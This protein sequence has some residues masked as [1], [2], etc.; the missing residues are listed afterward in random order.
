MLSVT[1]GRTRSCA[2]QRQVRD[3][4][5]LTREHDRRVH[6]SDDSSTALRSE[7]PDAQLPH[8]GAGLGDEL[9]ERDAI[10]GPLVL[11]HCPRGARVDARSGR[12][13]RA[14]RRSRR[15]LWRSRRTAARVH[16]PARSATSASRAGH[17]PS[18][19]RGFRPGS[20]RD[21]GALGLEIESL[22]AQQREAEL[23]QQYC[24]R[25]RRMIVRVEQRVACVTVVRRVGQPPATVPL[26]KLEG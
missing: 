23:E 14:A 16:E 26:S 17:S 18:G 20:A 5:I 1:S 21:H 11:E 24:P 6:G 4:D 19:T 10:I 15:S 9:G 7:D 12:R 25:L 8:A 2:G 3:R 22:P 13:L